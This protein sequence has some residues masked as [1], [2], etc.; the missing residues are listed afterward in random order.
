MC[1]SQ[2]L[3]RKAGA[4]IGARGAFAVQQTVAG[5]GQRGVGEEDLARGKR[6]LQRFGVAGS[7][8]KEGQLKTDIG[9]RRVEG[10]GDVPPFGAEIRMRAVVT[11][12]ASS[13]PRRTGA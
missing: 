4:E 6:R 7:A 12:K 5:N 13:T 3:T 1:T 2:S 10:A 8:A 9:L 11:G